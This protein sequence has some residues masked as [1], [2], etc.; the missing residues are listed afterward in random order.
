MERELSEAE[1]ERH[2]LRKFGEVEPI[3]LG[4]RPK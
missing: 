4:R 3:F 2:R 1:V